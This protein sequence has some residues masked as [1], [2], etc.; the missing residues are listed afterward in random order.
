MRREEEEREK[1]ERER[2]ERDKF[3]GREK[4][5]IKIFYFVCFLI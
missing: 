2:G 5:E 1:E 3:F 4:E